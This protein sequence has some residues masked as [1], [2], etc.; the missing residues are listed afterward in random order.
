MHFFLCR[1]CGNRKKEE[2]YGEGGDDE[3]EA[4]VEAENKQI[5]LF[6][7]VLSFPSSKI[8]LGWGYGARWLRC[9]QLR[10]PPTNPSFLKMMMMLH[11]DDRR[12]R[13]ALSYIDHA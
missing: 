9:G 6:F 10:L 8:L 12:L 3:V 11:D 2:V 5:L 1:M 7:S 13:F 4:L